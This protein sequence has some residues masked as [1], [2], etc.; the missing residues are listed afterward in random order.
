MIVMAD[1]D[2]YYKIEYSKGV[3]NKKPDDGGI[4]QHNTKIYIFK[5]WL[6]YMK[7]YI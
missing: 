1:D 7:S 6:L 2:Y 3:E 4:V 5:K